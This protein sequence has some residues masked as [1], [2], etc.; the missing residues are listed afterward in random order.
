M[1]KP[2]PGMLLRAEGE[3]RLGETP[4]GHEQR[5]VGWRPA[6]RSTGGRC[7]GARTVLLLSDVREPDAQGLADHVAPDLPLAVRW[8]LTHDQASATLDRRRGCPATGERDPRLALRGR[9]SSELG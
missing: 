3:L 1:R 2:K 9:R 6:R 5:C 7:G 4:L 8:I